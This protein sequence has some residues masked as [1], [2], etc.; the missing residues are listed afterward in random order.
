MYKLHDIYKNTINYSTYYVIVYMNNDLPIEVVIK[1]NDWNNG[2]I[3]NALIRSRYSQDSVEALVNNHLL[4]LADWQ[5][6]IFT[7]EVTGRL[8]D[9]DYDELQEWRKICKQWAKEALEKYLPV[10]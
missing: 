2:N 10:N 4:L 6:K 1:N 8:V 3:V 9:P 7:G 5:D